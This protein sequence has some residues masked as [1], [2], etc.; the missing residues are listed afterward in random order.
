MKTRPKKNF[1]AAGPAGGLAL[2]IAAALSSSVYGSDA[3][4]ASTASPDPATL[5]AVVV[6]GSRTNTRTVKNSSTPIDVLSSEDLAATGKGNLLQALQAVLP[7]LSL[8][9]L[10]GDL[11]NIV[12][13][14]QLRN[15]SPG[16][17]LVLINGK[18]R[19]VSAYASAS[20]NGFPGHS[21]TDLALIPVAGIDHVE[22]LRDG[23]SAIYGSDAIAGVVNVI[24]KSAREGGGVS[25]ESGSSYDGGGSRTSAHA[26]A[27]F[28]LG[29]KGFLD[30]F[31]EDTNQDYAL[32]PLR[33]KDTYL[34]YPA[35]G[36]NGKL[37]A[38]GLYNTLPAGA[39]PN[40]A[41]A[42]RDA[43][44][45]TIYSPPQYDTRALG[46]NFGYGF[47]ENLELYSFATYSERS[48]HS[49]QNVRLPNT[50]FGFNASLLSVYPDGFTP[51]EA[52]KERDYSIVGGLKGTLA[53]W[54][55]DLSTTYNHDAVKVYTLH[56]ANYSLS[57]PG[58]Q[59]DFYDGELVYDQWIENLDLRR[60]FDVG[61]LASPIDVSA[62]AEYQ[63]E[64]YRRGAGDLN[65]YYG[66]AAVAYPGYSPLDAVD[67]TRNSKAVYI[68]ASAN[69]TE[70]W[71]V[72]AAARYEDHSDFGNVSTGRLSTRFDFSEQ[73]AVR[74][75]ISNGFHAPSLAAQYF[76]VT[77]ASPGVT[78]LT[79]QV[80][81][82]V[83]Q[84]LGSTPLQPEKARNYTLGITF[85]PDRAVHAALDIYQIDIRNQIGISS[86][87]GY[88][89]T[90][91]AA[92]TDYSGS[93]LN[94][95]Q[96]AAIDA[97]LAK[98]GLSIA[99]GDAYYANYF[100][101]IGDT[102][103]R[104]LELTLEATQ[105]EEWG[106][107]RWSYALNYGKTDV[108]RVAA[109]PQVLQ[110]LPNLS[111]LTLAS[112]YNLRYRSPLFTQ[113]AGVQ[114]S[115]GPLSLGLNF[116]NYGPIKRINNGYQYE[117]APAVVTNLNGGYDF[118]HGWSVDLGID[119]L[120]NKY[121]PHIPTAAQ[122]AA[123]RA[124]WTF[125]YDT[126]TPISTL[127]GYYYGRLNYRF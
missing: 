80:G 119:N 105:N 87:I 17:T 102:R 46:A 103:T 31:A 97:L 37:V 120:F 42:T 20:S 23:A 85:D 125:Q 47:N 62:G 104:G 100:T 27:A 28:A 43:Y 92:V 10:G 71:F 91:P 81:S 53:G 59:T 52:T 84:A 69:I 33:Y 57:Y 109:I 48:A 74:G 127:G 123:N 96:K 55:W 121:A 3:P 82:N 12:R 50:V 70:R 5:D 108:T 72:D 90:N 112:Q 63:Y 68:G 24:L 45:Q 78:Y 73:F 86:Y 83:A 2:A 14:A 44:A 93:V 30:L 88:N 32:R 40:P 15:L 66:K 126:S 56:S 4:D 54:N 13:G 9:S 1:R 117:I 26:D 60:S 34:S 76:Q 101:N 29:D 7:S 98:A 65:S 25:L 6:T 36:A 94:V 41:E 58:G 8:E 21:W 64:N 35:I 49:R 107:L 110:A 99:S 22:V 118:G 124:T 16:Y 89:A 19:N 115:H 106:K 39:K 38:L 51:I 95:A 122:T 18:R 116:I 77:S 75:T 114:L 67:V 11:E 113:I 79:A 61:Q 111:L